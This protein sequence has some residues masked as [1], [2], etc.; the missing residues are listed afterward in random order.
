MPSDNP[1]KNQMPKHN[2]EPTPQK[3]PEAKSLVS[4]YEA[5]TLYQRL[6]VERTASRDD[7]RK[8]YRILTKRFHP[9]ISKKKD[10]IR[11][12]QLINDAHEVLKD[13]DKRKKYDTGELKTP[14]KA[15]SPEEKSWETIR[16]EAMQAALLG[17]VYYESFIRPLDKEQPVGLK[18]HNLKEMVH[19]PAMIDIIR[20]G[21]LTSLSSGM[22]FYNHYLQDWVTRFNFKRSVVDT[23]E[24]TKV[25]LINRA[26]DEVSSGTF[27]FKSFL[28]GVEEYGVMKKELI[29][30]DKKVQQALQARLDQ[31]FKNDFVTQDSFD[32]EIKEWKE[33]GFSTKDKTI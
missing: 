18:G 32:K 16:V 30:S 7:I 26:A 31:Q 2:I 28:E 13:D 21:A 3:T 27:A 1:F 8:A 10:A 24:R 20:A 19:S 33:I 15:P 9:D 25:E 5:M 22:F 6:G 29:L 23:D 14:G 12:S 11:I 17:A 4:E